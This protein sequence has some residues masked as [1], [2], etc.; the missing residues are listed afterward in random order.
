MNYETRFDELID[1]DLERVNGGQSND[2]A[3]KVCSDVAMTFGNLGCKT[4]ETYFEG[5][6]CG[7]G[8]C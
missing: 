8:W 5:M 6:A 3:A 4:I 1:D 2:A 7:Y